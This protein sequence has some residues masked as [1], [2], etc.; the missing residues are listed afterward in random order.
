MNIQPS[1]AT[2]GTIITGIS[3]AELGDSVW[4]EL[5]AA[6]LEF[7]LL[8]FPAQHLSH[9]DQ[10]AFGRRF[11]EIEQLQSG[12]DVVPLSNQR[13][14]GSLRKEKEHLMQILIGNEGWHTDSS[15]MPLTS[16]AAMLSA[17][18][19]PSSGGQT[20]WAD[21]RA[22]YETLDQA[23]RER[24][25]DLTAHHSLYYSQAKIG[26]EAK[27]G[28]SF[29]LHDQA[30]PLRPLVKVHPLTGRPA[31]FVGR[32]AYGIPG[33]SESE[34]EALIAELMNAICQP[35]HIYTHQWQPGD[36]A[37]WDNRA[38]LHRARPYDISEPRV[39]FHT[40]IAGDPQFETALQV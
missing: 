10:A 40:R 9:A 25:A 30:P 26:H 39:M 8:V 23:T 17:H 20:E 15:Y 4:Q 19:V 22:G 3:L 37:V 33:L 35:E 24:I 1:Q 5:E 13:C 21:A 28:A 31:L 16:K 27:P 32:H 2:L 6:F 7:G 11:G 34:S 12:K 38:L 18:T 36:I 29:G 14:D